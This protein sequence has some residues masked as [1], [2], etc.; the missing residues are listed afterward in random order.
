MYYTKDGKILYQGD[1]IIGD[2]EATQKEIDDYNISLSN[3]ITLKEIDAKL[4]QIDIEAVRPT[5]AIKV[6][7]LQGITPS[8]FDIDKLI[9]LET[10]AKSLR[11]Q[12]LAL[13]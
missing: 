11:Q 2:R 13:V 3:E 9:A 10:E 5:R 4:A 8:Q 1:M 7:E 12:R 6:A